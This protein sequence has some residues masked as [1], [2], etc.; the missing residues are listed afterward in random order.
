MND[1]PFAA[2]PQEQKSISTERL[3]RLYALCVS[4]FFLLAAPI[5]VIYTKE[6]DFLDNLRRILTSPSKLITDYFAL[7]G[8][9]STLF[10]TAV[11]GLLAN[12]VVFICRV[13]S[14][15]TTLAGYMLIVAHGFYGL[16]FLNMWPP[17]NEN[18]SPLFRMMSL[19]TVLRVI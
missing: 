3:I 13:R 17:T 10:N 6:W 9:G 16:N 8:L 5:A 11:C 12:A 14:N 1:T 18:P 19:L 7:G 4:L 15:A 2:C